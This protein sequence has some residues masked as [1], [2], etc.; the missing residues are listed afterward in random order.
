MANIDKNE[1][2]R[3]RQVASDIR[4]SVVSMVK[5]AKVGHIGG[6][7]SV[8]DILTALYF[9]VM[10]V[11][12][13]DPGWEDRDR[14]VLSKGHGAT[15]LY[16]A[17]AYRGFS[18]VEGLESFGCIDSRYQVHPDR[19]KVPGVEVSTGALGQ[20]LSVGIGMALAAKLEKKKYHTFVILGD[21]EIQE[22]QVWEAAMFA[23]HYK[24]E[25]LTV[26]LDY[27][28]V[29][30]MGD[31]DKIMDVAPVDKKWDSFGWIVKKIDGHDLGELVENLKEAK[32]SDEGPVIFIA[33]TTKGKG[34]SFMQ[35][36]CD[37][38]GGVPSEEEFDKAIGELKDYGE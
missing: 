31:V 16:S 6:S 8:T 26:I 24:I 10:E 30:L 11:K 3:L 21:G 15:A 18:P 5:E 37:W 34:V 2:E 19:K 29:Q 23:A 9:S 22:G 27:N 32:R 20:G 28:N 25:N 17:L 12:P 38:H 1:L 36:T 33:K 35:N 4:C 7:L 14:L 13:E